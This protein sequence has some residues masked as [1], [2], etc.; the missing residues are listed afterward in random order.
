MSDVLQDLHARQRHHHVRD[1]ADLLEEERADTHAAASIDWKKLFPTN[2]SIDGSVQSFIQLLITISIS[3]AAKND[4]VLMAFF[5][6]HGT[7]IPAGRRR[8]HLRRIPCRCSD[9]QCHAQRPHA[10]PRPSWE[11]DLPASRGRH[12]PSRSRHRRWQTHASGR[13]RLH[14]GRLHAHREPL[15]A[16]QHTPALHRPAPRR[17]L[18]HRARRPLH[19][20]R[21]PLPARRGCTWHHALGSRHIC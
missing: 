13:P 7:I 15:L 21:R 5:A 11:A 2:M 18:R 10:V 16:Q 1:A 4:T 19:W 20:A 9:R 6:S 12:T 17:R 3:A 14:H 8:S